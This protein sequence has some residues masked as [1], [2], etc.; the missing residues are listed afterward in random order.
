MHT[1]THAYMYA[2]EANI[3]DI[4]NWPRCD[5][6][7]AL[8]VAVAAVN[9][10]GCNRLPYEMPIKMSVDD[11]EWGKKVKVAYGK[12]I[13]RQHEDKSEESLS[14][15]STEPHPQKPKMRAHP[16]LLTD[17]TKTKENTIAD[18]KNV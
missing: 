10:S 6:P 15:Q 1:C 16:Q 11:E 8:Q 4:E 7:T 13:C 5:L 2:C 14:P 18:L 3:G 9:Q 12:T 17:K